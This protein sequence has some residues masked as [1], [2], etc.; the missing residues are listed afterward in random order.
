MTIPTSQ[1][2]GT[3]GPW[4]NLELPG[5][6][7]H[8]YGATIGRA[9]RVTIARLD[10]L[11]IRSD[12]ALHWLLRVGCAMCFIGHGAWGVI[13]KAGWLP[14][15]SVFG[16]GS[17]VAWKTM[18][19]IGA[20][21]ITLG[22]LA[23]AAP[24]RALMGYMVFWTL[25]TALLRPLAG[26]G[27]WEFIERGGNYGPPIALW[28]IAS[29]QNRSWLA[30]LKPQAPS[31]E[32]L[33][34]VAWVLRAC[35]ALLLV[36]H[37]AFALIQQKRILLQH[38][39]SIGVPAN[40]AFL[41]VVGAAE[42]AAAVAVFVKPSRT[43]LLGVAYWKIATELLYPISGGLRDGWEWVERGG[44]YVAP[45]ALLCVWALLDAHRGEP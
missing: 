37:G 15:Y 19:L 33:R 13:T 17:S 22:V 34:R 27:W 23:L 4:P 38:W 25:F 2:I 30:P 14:F 24:C 29:A 36:G 1:S 41:H 12:L 5:A 42:I 28:I 6:P 3:E 39:Q 45:L 31:P 32:T 10:A 18:P 26:M 43:L 21:D 7:F 44:D 9:W 11:W 8:R 35:I 16:I 40:A 20:V